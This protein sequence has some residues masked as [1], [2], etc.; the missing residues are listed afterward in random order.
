MSD[1]G[2]ELTD[3][4]LMNGA[5]S[6]GN[7]MRR[8]NFL[9]RARA[10]WNAMMSANEEPIPRA[11]KG[12]QSVVEISSELLTRLCSGEEKAM[13]DAARIYGIERKTEGKDNG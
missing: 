2:I 4:M 1:K 12:P 7:T 8:D 11:S 5:R 10:C 6:I 9:D 13:Q 3:A